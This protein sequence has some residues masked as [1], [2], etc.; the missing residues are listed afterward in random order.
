[1]TSLSLL[2]HDKSA[3]RATPVCR[4]KVVCAMTSV[5][6]A[7]FTSP[8]PIKLVK[9]LLV[10]PEYQ[11]FPTRLH[12]SNGLACCSLLCHPHG[13][14]IFRGSSVHVQLRA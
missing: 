12:S 8:R 13:R 11:A 3:T 10:D 9:G 7:S 2:T 6:H 14:S 1:M 5:N 4:A